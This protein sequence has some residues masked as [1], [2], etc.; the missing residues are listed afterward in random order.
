[1]G[2]G[3][4]LLVLNDSRLEKVHTRNGLKLLSRGK[5]FPWTDFWNEKVYQKVLKLSTNDGKDTIYGLYFSAHWVIITVKC[6][7]T[8]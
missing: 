7:T 3:E 5:S 8:L 6:N 4:T 2:N 1:M